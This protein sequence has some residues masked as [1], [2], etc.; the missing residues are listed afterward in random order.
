MVN[1]DVKIGTLHVDVRLN[2]SY[3]TMQACLKLLELYLNQND[4]DI[5]VINCDEP[6][7]WDLSV[8]QRIEDDWMFK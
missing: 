3:D 1:N 4:D 2:V 7:N 6:G 8:R 5:L